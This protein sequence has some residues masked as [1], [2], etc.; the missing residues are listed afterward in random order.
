M[1]GCVV[2]VYDLYDEALQDYVQALGKLHAN[3]DKMG[4]AVHNPDQMGPPGSNRP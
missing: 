4:Y 1:S 3:L 2:R